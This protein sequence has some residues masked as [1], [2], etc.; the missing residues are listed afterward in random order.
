MIRVLKEIGRDWLPPALVRLISKLRVSGNSFNGDFN[1]WEEACSQCNGYD[2]EDIL[3]K[4]LDSTLKVKRGEA[5][6]ERDSVL[7]DDIVYSYPLLSALMW[8]AAS[9]GGRLNV[10]DFGG[11]L[12]STYFQNRRFLQSLR[13]V[14]WNIVEQPHYV[15]A[16]QSFI[17]D[18]RLRF[19]KTIEQ[20]L[21]ENQPNVVVLSSVLQYLN[22]PFDIL[23]IISNIGAKCLIIDRTPFSIQSNDKIMIQQVPSYIYKASYPMWVFSKQKFLDTVR[24]NWLV[25]ATSISPEGKVQ[26][27]SGFEFSFEGLVM[28]ALQ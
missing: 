21:L 1:T 7:F 13:E 24:G 14:Q 3:S 4:V 28:E 25:F 18:D 15:A 27:D 11:S 2:A 26:S 9:D 19:Y 17:Q 6:F 23:K 20:C 16:G 10:L 5:A 12:G 8:G 22:V